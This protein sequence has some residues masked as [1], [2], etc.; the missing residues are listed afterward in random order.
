MA[1]NA[2]LQ[3]VADAGRANIPLT[4]NEI[5]GA[6]TSMMHNHPG[7]ASN[8]Q[9]SMPSSVASSGLNFNQFMREVPL[10]QFTK[11]RMTADEAGPMTDRAGSS[12][13]TQLLPKK[14]RLIRKKDSHNQTGSTAIAN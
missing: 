13:H 10:Q 6:S 3:I 4:R 11:R 5:H 7:H 8:G 14:Q 9:Q 2:T 12:G 1:S